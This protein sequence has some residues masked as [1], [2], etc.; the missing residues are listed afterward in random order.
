K[1]RAICVALS[2]ATNTDSSVPAGPRAANSSSF[3]DEGWFAHGSRK[4][5]RSTLSGVECPY[6]PDAVGGAL[7]I[8]PDTAQ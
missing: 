4:L 6:P 3:A 1:V 5:P 2:G 8:F 7:L